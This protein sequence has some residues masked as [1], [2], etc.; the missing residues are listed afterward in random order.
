MP[1]EKVFPPAFYVRI[2][3]C[4][5]VLL[6]PACASEPENVRDMLLYVA[7]NGAT[8]PEKSLEVYKRFGTEG[9][10]ALIRAY[11]QI[12]YRLP[13]LDEE[14]RGKFRETPPTLFLEKLSEN[15]DYL[16]RILD[17]AR[18]GFRNVDTNPYQWVWSHDE[19]LFMQ[20]LRSLDLASESNWLRREREEERFS[21]EV[22]A[23]W[24]TYMNAKPDEAFP[25]MMALF[26][27]HVTNPLLEKR[28]GLWAGQLLDYY[29]VQRPGHKFSPEDLHLFFANGY[30]RI[31][32]RTGRELAAGRQPGV[33]DNEK[34]Y[35]GACTQNQERR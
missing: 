16:R 3:L 4:V 8:N 21:Y 13:Y 24:E 20:R 29:A 32:Q 35:S 18:T 9:E 7:K 2:L 30:T 28:L 5:C 14:V 34:F 12:G 27:Q 33:P 26:A 1:S 15:K 17:I 19:Q 23:M 25:D 6:C 11:F 10:E 22:C 31:A